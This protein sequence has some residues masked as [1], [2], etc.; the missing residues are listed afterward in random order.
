[1][2]SLQDRLQSVFT[3]DATWG[4]GDVLHLGLIGNDGV[5]LSGHAY[6][7][8]TM[9]PRTLFQEKGHALRFYGPF[10]R[11]AVVTT[12]G[13]YFNDEPKF[14]LHWLLKPVDLPRAARYITVTLNPWSFPP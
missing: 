12:I 14:Y 8:I 10:D 9:P 5:E 3:D 1:M 7:R 6:R 13:A 11:P 4:A 2:K